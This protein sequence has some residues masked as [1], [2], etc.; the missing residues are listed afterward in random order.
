VRGYPFV[1]FNYVIECTEEKEKKSIENYKLETSHLTEFVSVHQMTF[2]QV[3]FPEGPSFKTM[4]RK[5]RSQLNESESLQNETFLPK[6]LPK[7]A[8]N[9]AVKYYK[10]DWKS[11]HDYRREAFHLRKYVPSV[12]RPSKTGIA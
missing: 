3:D 8:N 6:K 10:C 7:L 12:A 11:M 5:E 1:D 2:T 4:K 9:V